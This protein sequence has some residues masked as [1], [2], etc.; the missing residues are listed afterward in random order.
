M[1][2]TVAEWQNRPLEAS[3]PLVFSTPCA[4]KSG[5][6][7]WFATRRSSRARRRPTGQGDPWLWIENPEGSKFSLRVMNELEEPWRRGHPDRRRRRPQRFSPGDQRGV[8]ADPVQ[9]CIV[10][11]IRNSMDFVSWKDRRAIAAE[12]KSDL[13]RQGRRRGQRGA[14]RLDA[15]PWGEIPFDRPELAAKL[16]AGH[17]VF[18]LSRGGAADHLH[19]ERHRIPERQAAPSRA[20]TRTFSNRR[21]GIETSVSRLA[22][23]RRRMENAASA[24]GARLKTNSPS[25]STKRFVKA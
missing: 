12:L 18:R 5:T 20:N 11:L 16:G 22:S 14:R 17:P 19:D 6:R 24:N 25:C 3:Y 15:G 7:G 8:S 9:T 13:P 2:E 4:S 23:G 1:L 10:H 21:G